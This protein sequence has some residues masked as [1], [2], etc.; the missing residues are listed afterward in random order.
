M[1]M[2]TVARRGGFRLAKIR[3]AELTGASRDTLELRE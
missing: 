1:I 2:M 3:A